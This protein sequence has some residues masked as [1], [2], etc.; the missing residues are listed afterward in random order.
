MVNKRETNRCSTTSVIWNVCHETDVS[1]F[2]IHR[3][4]RHSN[5]TLMVTG[6][7]SVSCLD[8]NKQQKQRKET[9]WGCLVCFP[10]IVFWAVYFCFIWNSPI[11]LRF[12]WRRKILSQSGRYLR[13]FCQFFSHGSVYF[14]LSFVP[15]SSIQTTF[16][17]N[18]ADIYTVIIHRVMW[19]CL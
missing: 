2:K 14:S 18:L 1:V 17:Q 7:H 12:S 10:T 3:P 13:P 19:M 5:S 6:G 9:V 11:H 16:T 15:W 8:S 4:L